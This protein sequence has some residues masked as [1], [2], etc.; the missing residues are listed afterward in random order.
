MPLPAMAHFMHECL[1]DFN[2]WDRGEKNRVH[3]DLINLVTITTVLEAFMA[4]IRHGSLVAALQRQQALRQLAIEESFV[5]MIKSKLELTIR[6]FG[7]GLFLHH[8]AGS[9]EER[10]G[11]SAPCGGRAYGLQATGLPNSSQ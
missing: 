1:G 7:W 6:L 8:V 5:V 9:A 2:W 10:K 4:V 11:P 3:G